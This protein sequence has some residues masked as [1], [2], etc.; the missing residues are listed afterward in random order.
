[1]M[2]LATCCCSLA[3]EEEEAA[4]ATAA[5]GTG[6]EATFLAELARGAEAFFA[7]AEGVRLGGISFFF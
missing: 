1:M 6:E 7:D 4:G 3:G 5:A 2:F